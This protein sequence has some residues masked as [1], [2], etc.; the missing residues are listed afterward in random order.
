MQQVA[1]ERGQ[2]ET[3]GQILLQWARQVSEG[4]VITS[5]AFRQLSSMTSASRALTARTTGK[6]ERMA[7]QLVPFAQNPASHHPLSDAHI[8]TI[9]SAGASAPYRNWGL[10]WPYFVSVVVEG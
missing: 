4:I 3:D 1:N 9:S 2:S 7:E 8:A 6:V 5:V 10:K